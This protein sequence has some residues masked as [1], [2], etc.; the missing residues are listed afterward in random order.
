MLEYTA[1]KLNLHALLHIEV[2][3][4]ELLGCG[5]S[6]IGYIGY[7]QN[8]YWQVDIFELDLHLVLR[9]VNAII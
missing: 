9:I 2:Y 5:Y 8:L 4:Y 6:H 3:Q 7:W 1:E